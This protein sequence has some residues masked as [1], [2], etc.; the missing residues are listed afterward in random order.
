[1]GVNKIVSLILALA[2]SQSRIDIALVLRKGL[3]RSVLLGDAHTPTHM[4]PPTNYVVTP[5]ARDL[6]LH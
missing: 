6:Y 5:Y 2:S 1:M 4:E 3:S